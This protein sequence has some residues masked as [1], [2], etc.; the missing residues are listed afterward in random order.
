MTTKSKFLSLIVLGLIALPILF[1]PQRSGQV[2]GVKEEAAQQ[3][4]QNPNNQNPIK[5]IASGTRE[6]KDS[7][8]SEKKVYTGKAIWDE[9]QKVRVTT[10]RFSLG[11]SIKV[12]TKFSTQSLVVDA[13]R[14]NLPE[15]TILILNR[16]TFESLGG[17][18]D[19]DQFIEVTI[20][21][22]Q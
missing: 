10:D 9:K 7:S 6:K 20:S 19:T 21:L 15:G 1:Y 3:T 12:Q 2:L 4:A 18:P 17:K 14:D 5:D 13:P 11:S 22:D 8:A 16:Q